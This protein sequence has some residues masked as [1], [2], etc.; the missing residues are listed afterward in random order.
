M[1]KS[2][3]KESA[4]KIFEEVTKILNFNVYKNIEVFG[5]KISS[6]EVTNNCF[7]KKDQS[8]LSCKKALKLLG[9]KIECLNQSIH[10]S[11]LFQDQKMFQD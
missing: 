9:K 11:L 1:D 10:S 7:I 5:N 2:A 8:E 4:Q 3:K 6:N